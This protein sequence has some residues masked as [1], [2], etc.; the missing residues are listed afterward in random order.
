MA[1]G[2]AGIQMGGEMDVMGKVPA[3]EEREAA[4]D[5]PGLNRRSVDQARHPHRH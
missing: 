3:R 5:Q 1:M 2:V 4:W